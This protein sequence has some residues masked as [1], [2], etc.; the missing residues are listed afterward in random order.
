MNF[1]SLWQFPGIAW[2]NEDNGS[3]GWSGFGSGWSGFGNGCNESTSGDAKNGVPRCEAKAN[4]WNCCWCP[5]KTKNNIQ[6][7]L[8][9]FFLKSTIHW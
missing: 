2:R 8:I 7:Y 3:L 9:N 5:E 4:A 6:N 1:D